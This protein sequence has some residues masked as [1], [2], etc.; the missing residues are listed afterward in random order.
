MIAPGV[1]CNDFKLLEIHSCLPVLVEDALL[2]LQDI[3]EVTDGRAL[4]YIPGVAQ[5]L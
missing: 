4:C 3:E 2:R 1:A 5:K